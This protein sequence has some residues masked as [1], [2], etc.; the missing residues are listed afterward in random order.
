MSIQS[1]ATNHQFATSRVSLEADN[2]VELVRSYI[3]SGLHQNTL[4]NILVYMSFI[5]RLKFFAILEKHGIMAK[6]SSADQNDLRSLISKLGSTLKIRKLVDAH[7]LKLENTV[8]ITPS[9]DDR[10]LYTALSEAILK[11]LNLCRC[12]V[13]AVKSSNL[14]AYG[15]ENHVG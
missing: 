15:D 8:F 7:V 3:G 14:A 12:I 1:I 6:E 11:D 10:Q 2:D 5:D 4:S 9:T 13:K